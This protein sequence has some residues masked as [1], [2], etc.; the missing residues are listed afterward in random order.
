MT[1]NKTVVV[2]MSGGVDSS[3]TAALLVERGY[4]VIG[5]MMRLW[6]EDSALARAGLEIDTTKHF[7][8]NRCCSPEAV[9]DARGV[10][11]KLGI[12]FYL[13]NFE[14]DFKMYVVDY[15]IDGYANG[16]T[17][18]PCL[19]CNRQIK[20]GTLLDKARAL[21]ADYLATGHY[22]RV[23]ERNG[24]FELLRGVDAKKD[25]AYA[26]SLLTQEQ[27]ARV[28]FPLGEYSKPQVREMARRFDLRVSE[29]AESQDLC[30]IADGDYRNFLRRNTPVNAPALMP[31][32]IMDTRGNVLGKH[33]GL[34]NYTIGQ[35]KGLGLAMG[36][37][38]YVIE[39]NRATNQLIVGRADELGKREL[40][41][42]SMN[43][44]AGEPPIG[45][46]RVTAKIRY[47]A[48]EA[49]ATVMAIDA[50]HARVVFDEP[51]RDITPGQAVVLYDGQVCLG[52]GL[53]Q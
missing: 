8:S 23:R 17:P 49:A 50:T 31:G 21:G 16:V 45:E 4:T 30:F 10:C 36:E 53:I 15:F 5:L 12:P 33:T 43:W 52:G 28:M 11:Q 25:Q 6:A 42:Q 2:A 40:I 37:P 51:L 20:F 9:A 3:T 41:A 7:A 32:D 24:K 22:A 48:S 14:A 35:R 1:E 39:L 34:A 18:N 19:Q 38:L 26:L 29:K 13:L 47:R 46:I 44:I 27:L